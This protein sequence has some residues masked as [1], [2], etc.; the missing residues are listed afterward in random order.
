MSLGKRPRPPMRRTTSMT[1]FAGDV[2]ADVRV[3]QP[4]DK[5][6]ALHGH[7]QGHQRYRQSAVASV[8]KDGGGGKRT[9]GGS[10]RAEG[11]E[12][13]HLGNMVP[14]GSG[15]R[16]NF[17]DFGVVE[18]APFLKACSLCKRR[19]GPGRDTFM[20]RGDIAFCSLECRQQQMNLDERK[21]KCSLTSMK[22]TPPPTTS[23]SEQSGNGETVAAA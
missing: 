20:Y 14:P 17:G 6:R 7:G 16:R 21:E 9:Y 10:A 23:S 4:S 1:E 2:L 19:L 18:I 8:K 11:L 5:E 12:A 22:E 3:P 15:N 13:R